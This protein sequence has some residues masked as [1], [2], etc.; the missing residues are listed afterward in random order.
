[1]LQ[2]A[3]PGNT[4]VTVSSEIKILELLGIVKEPEL[5]RAMQ[6]ASAVAPSSTPATLKGL[7]QLLGGLMRMSPKATASHHESITTILSR[8]DAYPDFY[9][10][11]DTFL[12]V[13]Q[14]LMESFGTMDRA[15][16]EKHEPKG[17]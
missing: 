2:V 15:N 6:L 5:I 12:P 14:K 8:L 17:K 10:T 16:R 1:M 3:V 7:V 9:L 13:C 11:F 4:P